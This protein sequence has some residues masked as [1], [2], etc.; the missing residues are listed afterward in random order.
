MSNIQQPNQTTA[1]RN[2][3]SLDRAI[4]IFE[5]ARQRNLTYGGMSPYEATRGA[6]N[7]AFRKLKVENPEAFEAHLD[8]EVQRVRPPQLT[9]EML[10]KEFAGEEED[11]L[12][13]ET[14]MRVIAEL[15]SDNRHSEQERIELIKLAQI[16]L[17]P[18][19][20][21][22]L[23]SMMEKGAKRAAILIAVLE[24][25]RYSDARRSELISYVEM[26][27]KERCEEFG[28]TDA[29]A[30]SNWVS[31]MLEKWQNRKQSRRE[32]ANGYTGHRAQMP[33]SESLDIRRSP[34]PELKTAHKDPTEPTDE[35]VQARAEEIVAQMSA[36]SIETTVENSMEDARR[37]LRK[38]KQ[39][40]RAKAKKAKRITRAAASTTKSASPP[41]AFKKEKPKASENAKATSSKKKGKQKKAA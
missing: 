9:A 6:A 1:T 34:A 40:A 7:W 32:Q 12:R 8:A 16:F 30:A 17:P 13:R 26:H 5:Q 3:V 2:T 28:F 25:P 4:A 10:R 11:G 21:K 14:V 31:Q 20:E 36:Q 23:L 35:E 41:P 39:E 18:H 19:G 37:Q 22:E 29:K 24:E 33:R 15:R 38:E 27:F